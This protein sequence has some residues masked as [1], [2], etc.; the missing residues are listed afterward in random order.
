M[1]RSLHGQ[2]RAAILAGRLR[3]GVRLPS[4]R[5]LA[6]ACGV[7]RNTAVAAYE[8]LLSEGYVSAR[9]GS[10]TVVASLP[11]QPYAAHPHQ[12]R[13]RYARQLHRQWRGRL[14]APERVP[15]APARYD[16][17]IGVPYAAGFPFPIW[18]RL[19]GRVDRWL[20]DGRL[21][22]TDPQGLPELR[23]AI[24]R[25]VSYS[26]AVACDPADV[27]VTAGAQQAFDLLARIL[28]SPGHGTVAIENPGYPPV[29][30]AFAAHGARLVRVPVDAEGLQVE[31]I[32]AHASVVCVTP[33]HQFPLGA[34]MSARRR[35]ELIE[36]CAKQSAVIIEDDYDSEF[37]FSDRPLDALQTLD[38]SQSVCYVGTFS[39]SLLPELR[40][41]YIVAPHWALPALVAAKQVADGYSSPLTQATLA[42]LIREGH[43]TRHIRKMQR[44]YARRRARLL[45]E[46]QSACGSWLEPLPSVA[47]LHVAARLTTGR[48]EGPVIAQALAAGVAVRPL[49]AYYS[50]PPTVP[51][52]VFGYG[53]ISETDLVAGI[54]ALAASRPAR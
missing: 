10:G 43:L 39:K 52:L 9:R 23:T 32:P 1:L 31:R 5:S 45:D 11:S 3:P 53:N 46:L 29:G 6:R 27:I 19:S 7:S 38:R 26:R 16:F 54:R 36:R 22:S 49:G 12:G 41:G 34:A 33:S 47:G 8:L 37:R 40:L 2:L 4:T 18:R 25:H 48:A 51:G 28:T 35:S 50:A 44:L 24:A 15:V 14:L 13:R 30:A 20:R 42:L 17:Q 21:K